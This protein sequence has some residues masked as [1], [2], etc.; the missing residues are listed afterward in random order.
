MPRSTTPATSKEE[1]LV[2]VAT[3]VT[4]SEHGSPVVVRVG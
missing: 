2:C 4:S 1:M 3:Y